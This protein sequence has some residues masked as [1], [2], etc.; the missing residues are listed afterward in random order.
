MGSFVQI[1]E[2]K[3]KRYD[4]M[5]QLSDDY[6]AKRLADDRGPRPTRSLVTQDRDRP[7][8]Y[9]SIVEFPSYEEAM[10]NSNL[11][12]TDEFATS[13]GKLADAPPRYYNLDV[14]EEI[15]PE[16]LRKGNR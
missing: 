15:T 10:E 13:M 1:I 14:V 4:E 12:D 16:T 9:L 11:S 5:Q 6:I 3:T 2:F 8:V 7:G